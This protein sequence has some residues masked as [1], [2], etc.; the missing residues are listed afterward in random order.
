MP[1]KYIIS[2]EFNNDYQYQ[3][4]SF[5]WNT[6]TK[7]SRFLSGI[8]GTGKTWTIKQELPSLNKYVVLAPTNNA[9]NNIGGQ[10][11]H[12]YFNIDTNGNYDQ[13]YVLS[14]ASKLDYIVIDEV[15]MIHGYVL[16]MLYYIKKNTNVKFILIGDYRQCASAERIQHDYEH[17]TVLKEL[18][19]NNIQ[20]LTENKRSNQELW[21]LYDKVDEL[22]PSDFNSTPTKRH[23]SYTNNK[24]IQINQEMMELEKKNNKKRIFIEKNEQD[25]NSQDVYLSIRVP[26]M[27]V[28]NNRS[29]G[30]VNGS[31]FKVKSVIPLVLIDNLKQTITITPEIFQSHFYVNYCTTVNRVQGLTI[32]EPFTIH[33]WGRMDTRRRYTSIGRATSK[34]LITVLD[35]SKTKDK[36]IPDTEE[37]ILKQRI[38]RT[39]RMKD[40]LYRKR[41]NALSIINKIVRNGNVS[42]DYCVKHTQLNKQQL[43]SHL[44]IPNGLVPKGY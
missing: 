13:H 11:I 19:D 40:E 42:E 12:L 28:K 4:T 2:P 30:F 16:E 3:L 22:S 41:M 25:P 26:V 10:T 6:V 21:D 5:N 29:L 44:K 35:D 23:I 31:T 36:M 18:T 9:A 24:R 27:A 38:K 37:S 43:L 33:E 7:G 8:Q 20:V 14:K 32:N 17:S 34:S 1:D 39:N 15:S